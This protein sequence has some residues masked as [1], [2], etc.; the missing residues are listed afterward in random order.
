VLRE[1]AIKISPE[2][3]ILRSRQ[4]NG[5]WRGIAYFAFVEGRA[6]FTIAVNDDKPSAPQIEFLREL[7]GKK[8]SLWRVF[9]TEVFKHYHKYV[10]EQMDFYDSKGDVINDRVAPRIDTPSGMR[11]LLDVPSILIDEDSPEHKQFELCFPCSWE[12]VGMGL[13]MTIRNWQVVKV[14]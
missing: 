2:N 11:R 4:S 9:E 3:I 12:P 8:E 6:E 1:T 13:M 10:Y 7:L 5:F 14:Y